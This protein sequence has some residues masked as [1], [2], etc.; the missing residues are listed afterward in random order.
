MDSKTWAKLKKGCPARIE[1]TWIQGDKTGKQYVCG[2]RSRD[3]YTERETLCIYQKQC[4]FLYWAN[5][6]KSTN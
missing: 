4:P 5:I 2:A 3:E 1:E 6:I